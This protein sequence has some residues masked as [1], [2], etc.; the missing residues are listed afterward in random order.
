MAETE[1]RKDD[2]LDERFKTRLEAEL[3]A[4]HNKIGEQ[5]EEINRL[6]AE[7]D[8]LNVQ[9]IENRDLAAAA[10][11]L[12]QELEAAKKEAADSSSTQAN[13]RARVRGLE[14]ELAESEAKVSRL[15]DELD[16]YRAV[17]DRVHASSH[18]LDLFGV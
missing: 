16:R 6:G 3:S 17:N 10:V 13:L 15:E 18:V 9:R 14:D 12:R 7:K 11:D 4:A 5:N 8:A 2:A 1:E